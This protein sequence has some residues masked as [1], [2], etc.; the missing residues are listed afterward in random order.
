MV[1][2]VHS[3]EVPTKGAAPAWAW[4]LIASAALASVGLLLLLLFRSPGEAQTVEVAE[5]SMSPHL[6]AL[7]VNG[8][9]SAGR[10]PLV[11]EPK[12]AFERESAALFPSP[13][14]PVVSSLRQPEEGSGAAEQGATGNRHLLNPPDSRPVARSMSIMPEAGAET[15]DESIR[16]LTESV[17]L[18]TLDGGAARGMERVREA[19]AAARD[20]ETKS[21]LLSVAIQLA[22]RHS[23]SP[24]DLLATAL[25]DDQP[26]EV[27]HAALYYLQDWDPA[28]L[29]EIAASNDQALAT[30]ARSYMRQNL[31]NSGE[32]RVPFEV[33]DG[34]VVVLP[35][36]PRDK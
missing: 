14:V 20:A 33:P 15:E 8:G 34:E 13:G 2:D 23:L 11:R 9:P 35:S 25:G 7:G 6:T 26:E 22:R 29:E 17:L 4:L 10:A 27:R 28:Q 31:I 3:S 18:G 36:M 32:L 19:F 5:H 30:H 1:G 16:S 21:E 12:I 24:S